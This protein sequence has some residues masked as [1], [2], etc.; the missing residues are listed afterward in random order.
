MK[1]L[2]IQ[3]DSNILLYEDFRDSYVVYEVYRID[4]NMPIEVKRI[5]SWSKSGGLKMTASQIWERRKDLQGLSVIVS[6]A[7]VSNVSNFRFRYLRS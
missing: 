6:A 5:G 7:N 1:K 4:A 2:P 3:F